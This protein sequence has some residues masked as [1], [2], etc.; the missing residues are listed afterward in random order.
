MGGPAT[1]IWEDNGGKV[2]EKKEEE[3]PLTQEDLDKATE[4]LQN[5]I[6]EGT[7]ALA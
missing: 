5:G 3:A 4:V 2:P 1:D 7:P 6:D